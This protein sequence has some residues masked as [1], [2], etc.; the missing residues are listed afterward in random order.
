[1]QLRVA[2]ALVQAK[3]VEVKP[4]VLGLKED[5][6]CECGERVGSSTTTSLSRHRQT[7]KKHRAFMQSD[8]AEL[9]RLLK[10]TQT[11]LPTA[12]SI[13]T[14]T[15]AVKA[16][17]ERNHL[18]PHH[19]QARERCR[20]HLEEFARSVFGADTRLLT[21]GSTT[22]GLCSPTSDIDFTII[23]PPSVR[24]SIALH[25]GDGNDISTRPRHRG[26]RGGGGGGGG[27]NV[28]GQKGNDSVA[29]STASTHT[30]NV[31]NA[32]N[33]SNTSGKDQ[34]SNGI[35][36]SNNNNDDDDDDTGGAGEDA[37]AAEDANDDDD[38]DSDSDSEEVRLIAR[39]REIDC[40]VLD[41][42]YRALR[43]CKCYVYVRG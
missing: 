4:K 7:S 42:L 12:A 36:S 22:S 26:R 5:G 20:Q 8:N 41:T 21:F 23:V 33:K 3:S 34:S 24:A 40:R 14:L 37:N 30:L 43:K 38:D 31:G 15:A 9:E 16:H 19:Q 35:S 10:S 2:R 25:I 27:G 29:S 13:Q 32:D 6:V 1:V 17:H 39:E 18:T 28:S 11:P